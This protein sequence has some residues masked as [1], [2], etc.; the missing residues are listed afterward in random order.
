MTFNK[1]LFLAVSLIG[2]AA[3]ADATYVTTTDNLIP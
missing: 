3:F 1:T 2:T